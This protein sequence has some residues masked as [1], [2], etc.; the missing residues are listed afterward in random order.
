MDPLARVLFLRGLMIVGLDFC[1]VAASLAW[2]V[3]AVHGVIDYRGVLYFHWMFLTFPYLA[4]IGVGVI[5][6]GLMV[7]VRVERQMRGRLFR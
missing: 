5:I 4:S 7:Q 2:L 3:F 1:W 6:G